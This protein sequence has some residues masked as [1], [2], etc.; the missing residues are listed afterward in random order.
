[1]KVADSSHWAGFSVG[2]GLALKKVKFGVAYGK[3]HIAASSV[4]CNLSYT[5]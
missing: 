1:M 4:L 3:Y 5:F 2:A